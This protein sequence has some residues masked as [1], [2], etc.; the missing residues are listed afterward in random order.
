MGAI[1]AARNL[2]ASPE[3]KSKRCEL[4]LGMSTEVEPDGEGATFTVAY[5]HQS[6]FRVHVPL[7]QAASILNEMR[8]LTALMMARQHMA[9]DRG[10]SRLVEICQAARH[11]VF[12]QPFVDPSTHDRVFL[13]QFEQEVPLAVRIAPDV[14]PLVLAQ[15]SRAIAGTLN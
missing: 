14:L 15:L 6:P 12:I 8:S 3:P 2:E 9:L 5:T 10:A 13:F 4:L 11:P 7:M 1:V